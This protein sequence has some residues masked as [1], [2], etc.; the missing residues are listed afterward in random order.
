MMPAVASGRNK[1]P[2]SGPIRLANAVIWAIALSTG[3]ALPAFAAAGPQP[4]G[5]I[6]QIEPA[7]GVV[8][9]FGSAGARVTAVYVRTGQV[10][11]AG[12]LLMS[13][14]AAS[15]NDDAKLAALQLDTAKKIAEREVAAETAAVRVAENARNQAA[16]ALKIYRSMG[17]TLVSRKEMDRLEE[18]FEAAD[19]ALKAERAKLSL[20]ASRTQG[21]ILSAS[22]QLDLALQR[23][24]LRAPIDGS[25]LHIS[26]E[27]GS[28][29]TTDPA[30]QMGDLRTMY[31]VCQVYE[32]DMLAISPGMSATVRGHALTAPLHG[33]VDEVGRMIAP[34]S[35]L[36]E[37]RIR[38]DRTDPADRL[39]GME[40]DVRIER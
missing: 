37:V 7:S 27:V 33:S 20:T 22:R 6:G 26:R 36:G 32:G 10:V 3:P 23:T 35:R 12:T 38:L 11:K 40:V 21:D 19:L 2:F 15:P 29:L 28:Q 1:I 8:D 16:S 13:T 31:V 25:V 39:V 5:A 9:I 24:E 30:I 4:I 17:Q 14:Q 34:R 18:S